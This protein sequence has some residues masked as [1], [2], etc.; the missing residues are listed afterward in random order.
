[1]NLIRCDFCTE[2]IYHKTG[3][4]CR[5]AV[6]AV[7]SQIQAGWTRETAEDLFLRGTPDGFRLAVEN[8]LSIKPGKIRRHGHGVMVAANY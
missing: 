6:C 4:P 8:T 7:E 5:R 1:M 3:L 2:N